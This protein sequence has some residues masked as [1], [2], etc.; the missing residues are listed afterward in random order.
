MGKC[1]CIRCGTEYGWSDLVYCLR[2]ILVWHPFFFFFFAVRGSYGRPRMQVSTWSVP[3]KNQRAS[4]GRI[5]GWVVRWE[6]TVTG[7]EMIN[8]PI[9]VNVRD[10]LS[11]L[12][13][14]HSHPKNECID[15]RTCTGKRSTLDCNPLY[16]MLSSTSVLCTALWLCTP[17]LSISFVGHQHLWCPWLPFAG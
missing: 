1:V 16:G 7:Q 10:P 8:E 5:V 11:D 13:D 12:V 6:H 4:Q 9:H 17:A 14:H 2:S 15:D 3:T